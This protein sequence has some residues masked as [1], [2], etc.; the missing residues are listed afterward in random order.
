MHALL[1]GILQGITEF[2]PVSSS[3]HLVLAQMFFGFGDEMILFDVF[4]HFASLMAVLI[5]FRSVILELACDS[6]TELQR[7][8]PVVLL[9]AFTSAGHPALRTVAALCIGTIPAVIIGVAFKDAIENVFFTS[10]LPVLGALTITGVILLLTLPF[11]KGTKQLTVLRGFVVGC[12]QAMAVV[13]GISRSG[14]TISA[15]LFLGIDRE[16]AGEFSFLLAI[17]VIAGA[18][19]FAVHDLLTAGATTVQI[20]PVVVGM[21]AAFVSGWGALILLIKLIK[22]GRMGYFGFYCLAAAA[23]GIILPAGQDS[24][25]QNSLT[26]SETPGGYVNIATIPS[27]F[28]GEVQ[29]VKYFQASGKNRPLVVALH[30][31]SNDYTQDVCGEYMKRS[32]DRDWNCIFP[33]FRGPNVRP[34]ACGSEAAVRDILD[35]VSWAR[36][37]L[38]VD[39]R[40]VFLVGGSGGG[41]MSLLMAGLSPSTWTAVSAWVPIS[42]LAR[43]HSETLA[44]ELSYHENV[45]A[46]NGGAPGTSEAVDASYR[47]RS[48]ITHLWRAHIIPIDINAGIHDG[49]GGTFGGE[50]SVP[51]GQS[52]RAYNECVRASGA[53]GPIVDEDVIDFI[54]R[55]ERLPDGYDYTAYVD[56]TYGRD[57]LL[58]RESGLTRLTLFE[59]GHEILYDAAFSWFERF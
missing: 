49:H 24:A 11:K 28:D 30:T 20:G 41:H 4:L 26:P 44:R 53:K 54:E 18:T 17:P 48:P 34:E 39:P 10:R 33:N 14:S 19:V 47:E 9:S 2:L 21:I 15:A 36:E 7:E 16:R 57:I 23:A 42:D 46:V 8:G 38:S 51:V 12:A 1:L 59:G 5:V 31:W 13:P 22:R 56:S 50:G 27:S 58:R 40:R 45:E 55:E 32:A 43:W 25:G 6:V 37:N 3:G 35:T 29:H 52:I